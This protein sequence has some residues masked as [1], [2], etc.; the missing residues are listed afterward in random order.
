MV[1]QQVMKLVAGLVLMLVLL[2][3]IALGIGAHIS[4]AM[5]VGH[6]SAAHHMLIAADDPPPSH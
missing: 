2:S 6:V 5:Q 3:G 1:K 4:R